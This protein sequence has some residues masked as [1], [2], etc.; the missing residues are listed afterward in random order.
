MTEKV[1]VDL[2]AE[3]MDL[4]QKKVQ[5]SAHSILCFCR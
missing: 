5:T 3:M 1:V 2:E 4:L